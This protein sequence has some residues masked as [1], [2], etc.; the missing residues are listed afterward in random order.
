[1]DNLEIWGFVKEDDITLQIKGNNLETQEVTIPLAAIPN[2]GPVKLI[3]K[4]SNQ[5]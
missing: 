2:I 1:M 5:K 3:Q 4:L